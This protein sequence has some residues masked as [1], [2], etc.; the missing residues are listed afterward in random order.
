MNTYYNT[1]F[2]GLADGAELS[3]VAPALALSFL[4]SFFLVCFFSTTLAEIKEFCRE[5][6]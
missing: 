4:D 1:A 6:V 5:G 3:N 2:V